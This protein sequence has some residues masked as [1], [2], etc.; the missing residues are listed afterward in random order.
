MLDLGCGRG[1]W[2]EVLAEN[3]LAA[4]GLDLNRVAVEECAQAG[5]DVVHADAL[6][7]LRAI[8]SDT[9]G[10]IAAFHVIEHLGFGQLI[11]L[12]DEIQRVLRPDGAVLLETPNPENLIVGACNFWLDPTHVKPL[13]P[14]L[15]Q[16][17]C[18]TRGFTPVRS[19]ASSSGG[20]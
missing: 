11:A 12:L 2:L 19:P 13:P 16:F 1:E 5:L 4:R 18:E 10:A 7:H 3:G 17:L 6:E 20:L 15:M 14:E 8:K 9:L